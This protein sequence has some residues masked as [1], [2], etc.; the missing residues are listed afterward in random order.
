MSPSAGASTFSNPAP[1]AAPA[2]GTL[3]P[4]SPYP[5]T[6]SVAGM[7]VGL[8]AGPRVTLNGLAHGFPRDLD[9]LLVGPEGSS[10]VGQRSLLMSDVCGSNLTALT[11]QNFTFVPSGG[12]V[13]PANPAST[14]QG[15][16]SAPTDNDPASDAFPAPAP[17]VVSPANLAQFAGTKTNGTWQLWANDDL[18]GGVG[19]IAG[20]WSLELLPKVKC[21]GKQA[22]SYALV[23]TPG[24]DLISGTSA[25]D[26]VV[27][28]GGDDRVQTGLGK[29]VICGGGGDDR[30]FAGSGADRLFGQAGNDQLGGGVGRKDVCSGGKG[31]DRAPQCE[32]RKGI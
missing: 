11:G 17:P 31:K 20:G 8:A 5:S 32:K 1:I 22:T 2:S 13:L 18:G 10:F 30:I 4:A 28:L 23:G 9:I 7:P 15:G 29:D 24:D 16:I 25:N 27:G 3:G 21:G 6:I 14:C 19:T 26:V 12:L